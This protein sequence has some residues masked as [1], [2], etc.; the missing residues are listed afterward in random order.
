[1]TQQAKKTRNEITIRHEFKPGDAGRLIE[2]HGLIYSNEYGFDHTFEAYVAK[3]LAEFMLKASSRER[4]WLVDCGEALMGSIAIVKQCESEAQLRWFL[5]HPDLRR[6]GLGKQL[7]EDAV[8][9]C[10]ESKYEKVFLWTVSQLAP[11]A[12]L[13]QSAGFVLTEQIT[14]TMWGRLLTEQRY[15]LVL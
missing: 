4:I 1:V 3:P 14:H 8:G 15:D 6:R 5:L 10:R 9:F 7:I 13:Y 12:R 11:A 2:L